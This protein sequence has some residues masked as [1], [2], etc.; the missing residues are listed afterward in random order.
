MQLYT[1]LPSTRLPCQYYCRGTCG[2]ICNE[3][4]KLSA[5]QA[6]DISQPCVIHIYIIREFFFV[7]LA[8][9]LFIPMQ[10]SSNSFTWSLRRNPTIRTINKIY[11]YINYLILKIS[12]VTPLCNPKEMNSSCGQWDA[13]IHP[14]IDKHLTKPLLKL[15]HGR[16]IASHQKA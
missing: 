7:P 2:I 15:W 10:I 4:N 12:H 13:I 11:I 14:C 8:F 1:H 16:V 6:S 9:Y 3:R 5:M